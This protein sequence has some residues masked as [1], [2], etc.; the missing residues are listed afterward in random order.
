M[1]VVSCDSYLMLYTV[2]FI[3][4][5]VLFFQISLTIII[6]KSKKLKIKNGI[7]KNCS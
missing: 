1:P 3:E 4:G 5:P 2:N 6:I 7:R